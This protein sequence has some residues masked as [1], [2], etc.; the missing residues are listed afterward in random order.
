M[1]SEGDSYFRGRGE[2]MAHEKITDLFRYIRA[3]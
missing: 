2:V 3:K 1:W